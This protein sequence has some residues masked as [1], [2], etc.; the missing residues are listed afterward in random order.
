VIYYDIIINVS[1]NIS[2]SYYSNTFEV[3]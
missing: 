2:M 3:N 1:V